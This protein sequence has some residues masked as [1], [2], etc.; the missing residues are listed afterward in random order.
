MLKDKNGKI[1]VE[2]NHGIDDL[3]AKDIADAGIEEVKCRS[4][5]KCKLPRG[6]CRLCYGYDLGFNDMVK[7]GAAVGIVAAQSIGEPGTQLTMRTFHTGG[8]AH[9]LK[10]LPKVCRA[11]KNC[12]KRANPKGRPL[13]AKLTARSILPNPT[14]KNILCAFRARTRKKIAYD[15]ERRTL[16]KRRQQS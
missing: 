10:I 15:L 16:G 7:M 11:W 1:I 6:I 2:K 8:S 9:L 4:V 14:I 5:L 12:L 13:S 3:Q